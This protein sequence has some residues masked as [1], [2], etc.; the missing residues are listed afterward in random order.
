MPVA[1][2]CI[3]AATLCKLMQEGSTDG[4][5][6]KYVPVIEKT[7]DGYMV[8]V[9]SV[10]HPMGENHWVEWIELLADGRSCRC[11]FKP[12]EAPEAEFRIRADKVTAREY[13]NL[14]GHWKAEA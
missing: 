8:K 9:G 6:E 4:A 2:G 7:A 14:H 10:P 5:R 3:V 11:F 1:A 12:G 13:C